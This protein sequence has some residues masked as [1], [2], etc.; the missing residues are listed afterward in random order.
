[1]CTLALPGRAFRI[2]EPA[3]T[4][5]SD[6]V[7][8][9]GAVLSPFLSQAPFAFYGHSMGALTAYEL[10]RWLRRRG[11]SQPLHLIVSGRGA[12]PTPP[13]GVRLSELTEPAL[14]R[15]LRDRYGMREEVLRNAALMELVLPPIRAD[16]ALLD[17]WSYE[18]QEPLSVPITAFGGTEDVSV[19]RAALEAWRHE[20]TAKFEAHLLAGDHFFIN[21]SQP[22]VRMLADTLARIAAPSR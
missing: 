14:Q 16:F 13:V 18:P 11:L 9:A 8:A 6:L 17:S 20:T 15:L 4:L 19:P 7:S 22:F 3:F 1:M 5:L 2:A 21:Q 12:P 10:T